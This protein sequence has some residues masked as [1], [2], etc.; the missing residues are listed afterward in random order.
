MKIMSDKNIDTQVSQ[1]RDAINKVVAAG[2]DFLA[3]KIPAEKM[4]HTMVKAV[5]DYAKQAQQ[6]GNLRP[7]S[8]EAQDLLGVL[9]EIQGCGSGFLA[10]RCDAAC[11]ARTI[12]YIVNEFPEE[13]SVK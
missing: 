4:A 8:N 5:E 3:N 12:T 7:K 6:E 1:I 2:P 11:V 10:D 9:Q 13:E